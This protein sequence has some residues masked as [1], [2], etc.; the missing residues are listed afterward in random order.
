MKKTV[1][2]SKIEAMLEKQNLYSQDANYGAICIGFENGKMVYGGTEIMKYVYSLPCGE[3]DKYY[4]NLIPL[5]N[6]SC[7]RQEPDGSWNG[8]FA[9]TEKELFYIK[10]FFEMFSDKLKPFDF[11]GAEVAIEKAE[12]YL[13]LHRPKRLRR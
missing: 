8:D 3:R 6:W 2:I 4:G 11:K 5:F 12:K 1:L 13:K 7:A 9:K 10:L